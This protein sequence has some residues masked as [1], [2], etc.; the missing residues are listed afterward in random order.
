MPRK[1][2]SR[3]YSYSTIDVESWGVKITYNSNSYHFTSNSY[4]F[5]C[6]WPTKIILTP[7]GFSLTV[8]YVSIENID[9]IS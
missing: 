8:E 7:A 9:W 4:N 5:W 2:S 1:Q 6:F 3:T